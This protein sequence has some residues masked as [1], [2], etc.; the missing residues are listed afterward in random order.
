MSPSQV[1]PSSRAARLEA[2][3]S[4]LLSEL[5][6][7]PELALGSAEG[8]ATRS[9]SCL[10]GE[11]GPPSALCRRALLLRSPLLSSLLRLSLPGLCLL[12]GCCHRRSGAELLRLCAFL[13]YVSLQVV[14]H[15]VTGASC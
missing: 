7:L 10:C 8:P 6:E 3:L 1:L 15:A 14:G 2:A 4:R 12:S 11:Q 9:G 13:S 5:W